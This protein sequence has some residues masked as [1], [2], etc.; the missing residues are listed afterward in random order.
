MAHTYV[1]IDDDQKSLQETVSILE[2]FSGMQCLATATSFDEGLDVILEYH[3]DVVL[4][5]INPTTTSSGL[6]LQL[7]NELYRYMHS[8]PAII[9]VSHTQNELTQAIS[10]GVHDFLIKPIKKTD[11]RKSF[12]KY[13]KIKGISPTLLKSKV[14]QIPFHKAEYSSVDFQKIESEPEFYGSD[15]MHNMKESMAVAVKELTLL[16]EAMLAILE[17]N[18]TIAVFEQYATKIA[19][20]I[21][22]KFSKEFSF[23]SATI[24]DEIKQLSLQ[25]QNVDSIAT[26]KRAVICIKSYGDYRFLDLSE[27]AFLKADNNST[28]ITLFNGDQVTAFKNLKYFEENLPSNYFR[29]HNSF[30]VNQDFISR[31]HTGNNLCYIKNSK[32]QIP[33]SKGYKE[34]VEQILVFLAGIAHKEV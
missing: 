4:L 31:I 20:I 9:V 5:E 19:D 21:D 17:T 24:V 12:L 16:K 26:K 23:D 13:E 25:L 30:I 14:Q 7:I 8:I 33:F 3:P 28:D 2:T 18:P 27:I 1:V 15:L 22:Q 6:S 10:F 34:N 32:H 29:I 11:V